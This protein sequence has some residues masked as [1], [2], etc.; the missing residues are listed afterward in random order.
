MH[1][2]ISL[3][4]LFQ[5]SSGASQDVVMSH[6]LL[7]FSVRGDADFNLTRTRNTDK[8][9]RWLCDSQSYYFFNRSCFCLLKLRLSS[10][11]SWSWKQIT[12]HSEPASNWSKSYTFVICIFTYEC[13]LTWV[14]MD[15][16]NEIIYN[17]CQW[18]WWRMVIAQCDHK[19]RLAWSINLEIQ[20]TERTDDY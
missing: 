4:S 15:P 2:I 1:T 8:A 11:A 14:H 18:N 6:V 17:I 7:T 19:C 16:K 12:S 13:I 10:C 5:I 20:N 9:C 3:Y